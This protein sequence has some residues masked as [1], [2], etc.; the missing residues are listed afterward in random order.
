MKKKTKKRMG[1]PPKD[2]GDK[3][4]HRVTVRLTPAQYKKLLG[5][6][7]KAGLPVSAYIAEHL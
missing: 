1:R 2:P 7:K 6:A 3:L 4:S 5:E